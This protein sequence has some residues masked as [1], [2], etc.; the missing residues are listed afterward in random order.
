MVSNSKNIA[1]DAKTCVELDCHLNCQKKECQ[2]CLPCVGDE[3]LKNMHRAH[4]EHAK[5]GGFVRLFPSM[6]HFDYSSITD[7][8]K[9]NQISVKWFEAKCRQNEDF[10]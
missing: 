9:N 1:V 2:L 8:T 10:C 3:N 7:M 5:R 4:R 6:K